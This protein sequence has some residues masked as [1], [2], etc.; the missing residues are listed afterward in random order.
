MKSTQSKRRVLLPRGYLSWSAYS[1]FKRSKEE[2]IRHYFYGEPKEFSSKYTR[3]G[4]RFADAMEYMAKYP[5]RKYVPFKDDPILDMIARSIPRLG[6]PEHDAQG[7]LP[8][9]RGYIPLLAKLDD[10]RPK[11]HDFDEYKTGKRKW[12]QG[13][14]QNHG[15]LKFYALILW[16]NYGVIDQRKRLVWIQTEDG[17]DGDVVPTGIVMPFEVKYTIADLLQF[18]NEIV[19]VAHEISDLYQE[20]IKQATQ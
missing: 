5:E 1:T 14:A 4:K 19:K 18:G 8:S 10:Y 9:S 11:T 2:Y 7:L 12:T 3:F 6:S 17:P 15:Q 20:H 13:M 16:L